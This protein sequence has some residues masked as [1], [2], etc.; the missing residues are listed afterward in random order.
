TMNCLIAISA[1]FA[2]TACNH[3]AGSYSILGE[4]QTFRQNDAQLNT[5]IDVLWVIDN[6]GSMETS[7]KN[8]ADNFPTFIQKFS[9]KGYDFKLAVT[10]TDSYLANPIWNDYYNTV[11][12]PSYYDGL[13]QEQIAKF[14]DG[15]AAR[16][17][18]QAAAHSGYFF[19]TPSTP[20][21]FA[22]FVIN[23]TQGI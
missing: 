16:S 12:K 11:P 21:L 7:Q 1:A 19:L 5:K 22:N 3:G 23:A 20:N 18:S 15:V 9:D 13:P 10:T 14:R 17:P 8:L 4:S 6:S 2:L